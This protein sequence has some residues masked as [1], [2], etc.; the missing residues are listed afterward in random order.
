VLSEHCGRQKP[1]S[2]LFREKDQYRKLRW[3]HQIRMTLI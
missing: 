3:E 2:S 1:V